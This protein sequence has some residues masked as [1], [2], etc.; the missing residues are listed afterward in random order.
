L[1]ICIWR[2]QYIK[3]NFSPNFPAIR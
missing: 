1:A 3:L 2:R